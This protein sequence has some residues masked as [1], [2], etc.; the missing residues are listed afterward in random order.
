MQALAAL[1]EHTQS[2]IEQEDWDSLQKT[3]AM[4]EGQLIA[5]PECFDEEALTWL[6]ANFD[7]DHTDSITSAVKRWELDLNDKSVSMGG[8][9]SDSPLN[10]VKHLRLAQWADIGEYFSNWKAIADHI[11]LLPPEDILT[12]YPARYERC[13][14]EQ[15]MV[16][17]SDRSLALLGHK[18]DTL[19]FQWQEWLR[20]ALVNNDIPSHSLDAIEIQSAKL[21]I[22]ASFVFGYYRKPNEMIDTAMVKTSVDFLLSEQRPYDLKTDYGGQYKEP[23]AGVALMAQIV[24]GLSLSDRS[25]SRDYIATASRWLAR[26]QTL[27][28]QWYNSSVANPI[29]IS[30]LTLDAMSLS[31]PEEVRPAKVTFTCNLKAADLAD[32][33]QQIRRVGK[34]QI[35]D[36]SQVVVYK[37]QEIRIRGSFNWDLL[38]RLLEAGKRVVTLEEIRKLT[39]RDNVNVRIGEL[40]KQLRSSEGAAL[41]DGITSQRGVGYYMDLE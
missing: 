2:K 22:A 16:L 8:R 9:R 37:G 15:F 4:F 36:T 18:V 41:A 29:D 17:R 27:Y 6:L 38:L 31:Y 7:R 14:W 19:L 1:Q 3:S 30:V 10:Y 33:K 24:H 13:F 28:G 39:H 26:N 40:K 5:Y 12:R 34:V 11:R 35:D 23:S 25:E 21:T 32:A 20:R